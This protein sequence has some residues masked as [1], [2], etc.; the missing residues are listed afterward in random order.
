MCANSKHCSASISASSDGRYAESL[1]FGVLPVYR[2]YGTGTRRLG[3]EI[4]GL[5]LMVQ[6]FEIQD[7]DWGFG[8]WGFGY[9]VFRGWD[10]GFG[11]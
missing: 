9:R 3:F 4:Q 5:E 6:G 8:V 11:D 2:V 10:L 1:G 7:F